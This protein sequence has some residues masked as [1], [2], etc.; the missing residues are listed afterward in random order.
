MLIL[1]YMFAYFLCLISKF[2]ASS[3]KVTKNSN[4]VS[5]KRTSIILPLK[6]ADFKGLR[7]RNANVVFISNRSN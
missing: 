6:M 3:H 1:P 4:F 2:G 7:K 5:I